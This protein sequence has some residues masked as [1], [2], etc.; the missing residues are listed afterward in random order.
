M[1]RKVTIVAELGSNHLG[2]L[3]TCLQLV[4][5]A[6]QAGADVA[7]MQLFTKDG[8]THPD[9]PGRDALERLAVPY[10]WLPEIDARARRRGIRWTATPTSLG[11]VDEL[12][13]FDVPFIKIA[14]GDLTY[15]DL[16]YH[17]GR[18]GKPLV[19]STGMATNEEIGIAVDTANEAGEKNVP[20]PPLTVLLCTAA[21]PAAEGTANL[22]ILRQ[23]ERS[24]YI[25]AEN[26]GF[27]DHTTSLLLPALAVAAGAVMIEK[28]LRLQQTPADSPDYPHS[29]DPM[30]FADMVRQIRR[31]EAA[32]GDS[33]K[34]VLPCEEPTRL[35][36]RRGLY[37]AADLPKGHQVTK[38]DLLVVRPFAEIGPDQQGNLLHGKLTQDVKRWAPCHR[39]EVRR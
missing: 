5:A 33:E 27:S 22:A 18:T 34:R 32:L 39:D 17:A 30:E 1:S 11:A 13:K 26:Y 28:H 38:S 6:A 21:Y 25:N 4:D 31:A 7:K 20:W 8:L 2:D 15:L 36:A 24:F 16:I 35:L 29:L 37:W 23:W 14:S 19:L 10:T 9:Y 3:D 12:T